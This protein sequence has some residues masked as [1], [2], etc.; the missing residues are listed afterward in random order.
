MC[1]PCSQEGGMS[2][3]CDGVS[4]AKGK[5]DESCKTMPACIIIF[6]RSI[7][8]YNRVESRITDCELEQK[9]VTPNW[10]TVGFAHPFVFHCTS[11]TIAT[12]YYKKHKDAITP[13]NV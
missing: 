3:R 13:V 11:T 7:K 10:M 9:L 1:N 4:L 2:E 5:M 8:F 12:S 6:A